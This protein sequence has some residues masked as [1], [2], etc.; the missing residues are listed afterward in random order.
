MDKKEIYDLTRHYYAYV[1]K[2]TK[3]HNCIIV[4]NCDNEYKQVIMDALL[5][6]GAQ[7]ID[8]DKDI[9]CDGKIVYHDS[10]DFG[11]DLERLKEMKEYVHDGNG[12]CTKR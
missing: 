2:K 9:E 3:K 4:L 6:D 5:F 7:I 10:I 8:T 12:T 11:I 1:A